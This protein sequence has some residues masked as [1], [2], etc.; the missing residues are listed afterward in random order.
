MKGMKENTKM[1]KVERG[2]NELIRDDFWRF[3]K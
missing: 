1:T 2:L 3:S